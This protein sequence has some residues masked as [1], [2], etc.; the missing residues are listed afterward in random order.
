MRLWTLLPFMA[1][2]LAF[3]GPT[4]GGFPPPDSDPGD[5][6]SAPET[7]WVDPEFDG[8]LLPW[9]FFCALA[10]ED[11]AMVIDVRPEFLGGPVPPGMETARPIPLPVFLD[12]FVARKANQEK[13]LLI[14]DEAGNSYSGLHRYL[15]E[16]GYMD[17][18]F[19]SGG[20][21]N[22][23]RLLGGGS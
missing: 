18:F 22:T 17:Y 6:S 20:V 16:Y 11:D 5:A 4:H 2:F 14:F 19:L 12:N 15:K 8:M 1:L 7:A 9:S 3:P 23:M 13:T 21:E 10:E